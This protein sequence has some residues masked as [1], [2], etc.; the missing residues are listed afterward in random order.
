M[1][2][3]YICNITRIEIMKNNKKTIFL[4]LLL[5]LSL[6]AYAERAAFVFSYPESSI[7]ESM[8]NSPSMSIDLLINGSSKVKMIDIPTT[9]RIEVYSIL[10]VKIT[11]VSLREYI[12][13]YSIDLP[14][15]LYILKA[16][17]TAQKV[18]V[19]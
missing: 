14:K 1:L 19:K 17:R 15:G 10:G 8:D 13:E 9:G 18:V 11:S 12:C 3:A 4:L 7:T 6:S 16:G 2:N 5:I